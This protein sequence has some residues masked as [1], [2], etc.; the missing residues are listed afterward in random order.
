MIAP[1][2]LRDRL[3]AGERLTGALVRMPA[4][5]TVEMLAVAGFDFALV[6]CEHGPADV[7]DLRRHVAAAAAFGLPVL[8]R[9]GHDD[10]AFVLRA[11]DGGAAG[12]VAPHVE[13]AAEAASVVAAARYPPH[14]ER[15]FATYSRAGR[16]GTVSAAEHRRAA[17]GALVLVMLE[18]PAAVRDAAA[19]VGAPG[20]DGFLVGTSDLAASR[21]PGDPPVADLLDAAARA[22][23]SVGA[24]RAELAGD[25]AQAAAAFAGGARIV[26]YNLT[27][28]FMA[29]LAQL[30]AVR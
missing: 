14:G 27:Q 3:A 20:V 4:E 24:L 9:P 25:P 19:I 17:D 15:G 29:L 12:I 5:E 28:A 8:V 18:S 6:D 11:L 23:A 10:P 1:S 2:V 7:A 22:G 16:Y 13:S 30:R 21:G 26:V